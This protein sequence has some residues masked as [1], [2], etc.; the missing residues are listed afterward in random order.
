MDYDHG[1]PTKLIFSVA[2]YGDGTLA[3]SGKEPKE[4]ARGLAEVL[5]TLADAVEAGALQW[6]EYGEPNG[7]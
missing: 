7:G 4:G 2:L 1:D 6:R 3:I 5:R